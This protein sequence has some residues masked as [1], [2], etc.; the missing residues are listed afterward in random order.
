MTPTS[1]F[2]PF[3]GLMSGLISGLTSSPTLH[4]SRFSAQAIS[5]DR[6]SSPKRAVAALPHN[7]SH[8]AGDSFLDFGQ[9]GLRDFDGPFL[10][11]HLRDGFA[12]GRA[13]QRLSKLRSGVC[14]VHHFA[15]VTIDQCKAMLT[16]FPILT[17]R[18]GASYHRMLAV[19]VRLDRVLAAAGF[20]FNQEFQINTLSNLSRPLGRIRHFRRAMT[21][22]QSDGQFRGQRSPQ[23][24]RKP[25]SGAETWSN[26]E[27]RRCA[28]SYEPSRNELGA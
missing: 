17:S 18:A 16:V 24:G 26:V 4:S 7:A 28:V 11:S 23:K 10:I 14:R 25:L 1:L 21:A 9:L 3:D 2:L 8:L 15:F 27:G 22:C 6:C 20:A 13:G 12:E 5:P 19:K